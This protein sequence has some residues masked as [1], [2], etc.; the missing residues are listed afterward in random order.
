[1]Y[2]KIHF[3]Y[4]D[5]DVDTLEK[6]TVNE[7]VEIEFEINSYLTMRIK[8]NEHSNPLEFYKNNQLSFKRLSKLSKWLFSITASP[9]ASEETFSNAGDIIDERRSRLFQS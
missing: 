9:V 4:D 6:V 1:M 7:K 2:F 8:V 5:N 3:K